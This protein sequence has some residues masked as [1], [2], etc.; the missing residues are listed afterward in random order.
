LFKLVATPWVCVDKVEILL[1][2]V[3][4]TSYKSLLMPI[5]LNPISVTDCYTKD[6]VELILF[7][8]LYTA[9]E[10]GLF[11]SLV[12]STLFNPTSYLL[13]TTSPVLPATDVTT[14]VLVSISVT[15]P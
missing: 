8:A 14:S 7:N 6:S 1:L 2:N 5:T 4:S 9:V 13:K 12:L 3:V 11:T 15:C 10:I